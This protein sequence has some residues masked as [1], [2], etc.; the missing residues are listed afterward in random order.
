MFKNP[1]FQQ[2]SIVDKRGRKVAKQKNK[3]DMKK[4]YKLKDEVSLLETMLLQHA[5]S[6]EVC[7]A[8]S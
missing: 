5:H 2:H 1:E 6:R 3:E 7:G 4:Y 8:C